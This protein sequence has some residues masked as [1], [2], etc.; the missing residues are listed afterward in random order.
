M[1]KI[2]D[3]Q[4]QIKY[5]FITDLWTLIKEYDIPEDTDAYW[6]ALIDDVGRLGNK[7][8]DLTGGNDH[9]YRLMLIAFVAAKERQ[10]K[11]MKSCAA[12]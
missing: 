2:N 4:Q 1:A 11:Q 12:S 3:Q 10:L 7:Y 5:G 9:M 8:E 6:D